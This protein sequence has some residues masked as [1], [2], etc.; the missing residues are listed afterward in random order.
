MKQILAKA[1]A[2]L[3]AAVL[4]AACCI[5]AAAEEESDA[6][7]LLPSGKTWGA[8]EYSLNLRLGLDINGSQYASEENNMTVDGVVESNGSGSF[9]ASYSMIIFEGDQTRYTLMEGYSDVKAKTPVTA[10]TVYDWGSISKTLVWV[11]VMQLWEQGK[12]DLNADVRDYLPEGFFHNLQYDEPITMIN[13]MNHQGGWGE[14]TYDLSANSAAKVRSLHDALQETEPKQVFRPGTVASYSNWGAALAGYV[15]ECITGESFCDYVHAHIFE[16]LGMEHTSFAPDHSDNEWVK[17]RREAL[18]CYEVTSF[19]SGAR[20][21]GSR[22]RYIELYPAGSAVGTIGDL[23]KYAQ[24]FVNDSAPLFASPETQEML[25]SPSGFV[26]DSD[27]PGFYHGF[28]HL[29]YA[30]PVF[31]HDGGTLGCTSQ[32]LFDRESKIGFV[33]LTNQCG[34]MPPQWEDF[35]LELFGE[36]GMPDFGG[37]SGRG[38]TTFRGYYLPNRSYQNGIGLIYTYIS[39]VRLDQAGTLREIRD[40]AYLSDE[41]GT[42]VGKR[43]LDDGRGVIQINYGSYSEAR[44]YVL[45][46]LLFLGYILA[47]II[48]FCLLRIKRRLKKCGKMQQLPGEE[49]ISAAQ[50]IRIISVLCLAI[51]PAFSNFGVPKLLGTGFG[52]LQ[53]VT[54]LCCTAAAAAAGYRLC[55]KEAGGK[56]LRS[57]IHIA[58]N[59][60]SAAA[61]IVFEMYHFWNC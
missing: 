55:K 51:L 30:V 48:G 8:L 54:V 24:A 58:G 25:F 27:I 22:D 56:L 4:S 44:F 23:A 12:L 26:A 9:Y 6:S 43:T 2:L 39:A 36:P 28:S 31:G 35:P 16:P 11:S 10:E 21:L 40:G 47:A 41:D 34:G 33:A 29:D 3:A 20:A 19:I 5:P 7:G 57:M 50:I 61:I 53:I 13:L 32:M 18:R 1:A 60:V 14:T 52:L 38:Q 37:L 17:I 49:I 59:A 46:M 15:I 42:V 45:K